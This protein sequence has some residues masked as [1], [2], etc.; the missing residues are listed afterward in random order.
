MPL[1]DSSG[2]VG[3]LALGIAL[4]AGT[5][6][7]P[8][9]C[10][11]AVL[12][13]ANRRGLPRAIATSAGAALGDFTYATLG[14]LGVGRWL[15]R[16]PEV[17]PVLRTLS[18]IALVAFG[19]AYLRRR[20]TREVAGTTFGGFAVG[21]LTLLANPGA[22]VTWV[23]V[24]GGLLAGAPIEAQWC[25]VIG[26]ALGTFTWF[27]LV[28]HLAVRGR[29]LLASPRLPAICGG[30]LIACGIVSLVRAGVA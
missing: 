1:W 25:A 8:G 28:A 3:H 11:V 7:L 10:G 20:P 27:S 4:G 19:L 18:A 9:P 21:F 5:S 26:I 13:A 23:V 24:V 2:L 6:V 16:Y 22:L 12:D 30:L 29:H 14:V 17:P 15:A